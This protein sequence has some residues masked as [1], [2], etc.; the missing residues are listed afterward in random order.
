MKRKI[1]SYI[2]LASC[3]IMLNCCYM[4]K[5]GIYFVKI[6]S[7]A[8]S[9]EKLYKK[10]A[11][12]DDVKQFI[13]KVNRIL[14]FAADSI[15]LN[16]NS[17]F[18]KYIQTDKDHIVDVL[19]ASG[20]LDFSQY[21]WSFPFVGL[22][23]NKGFFDV[24]DAQT[25]ARRL[26][27]RGYDTYITHAPAFST[28]G[29]FSDPVYSYMKKYSMFRLARTIIHEQTH[30]TLFIKNQLQFN[31]E[32]AMFMGD[33]GALEYIAEYA[34]DTS[35]EYRDA[36]KTMHDETAYYSLV[37]SLYKRLEG[38]YGGNLSHEEKLEKKRKIITGFKDSVEKN[39]DSIFESGDFK[40]LS[41]IA[42]NNAFISADMTYTYNLDLF[43]EV[44]LR[45]N[46]SLK[47]TLECLK[48]LDYRSQDPHNT[49]KKFL[50]GI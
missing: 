9:T 8:V 38:V 44:F 2:L 25:E 7:R 30:A 12:P 43:K 42:I 32:L 40:W 35:Q 15:G 28:L 41:A 1:P 26:D 10:S 48:K 5:Q 16:R 33:E 19:Y 46:R 4:A 20:R 14:D 34:G 21:T 37:K 13:V 50:N 29:Y 22:F 31:E 18:R 36:I 24:K 39:Y 11:T 17:N 6:N 45:N 27:S 23:P 47:K 3:V 49:V